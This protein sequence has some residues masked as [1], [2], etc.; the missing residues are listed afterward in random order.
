MKYKVGDK[1]IV[2]IKKLDYDQYKASEGVWFTSDELDKLQLYDPKT[3]YD[4]STSRPD[5]L[6]AIRYADKVE[7]ES[8]TIYYVSANGYSTW[9]DE[10]FDDILWMYA[11]K[12]P[13]P[14]T[15]NLKIENCPFPDHEG[16]C[17]V[18]IHGG[19]ISYSITCK[20]GYESKLYD[21]E[22]KAINAHN[23]ICRKMMENQNE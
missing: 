4:G 16:K 5:G 1:F 3:W 20:C 12:F 8:S 13:M 11:N 10:D 9:S 2:E 14:Q 17:I 7:T 15:P 18:S 23:K 22:Q 21:T 19:G 6:F